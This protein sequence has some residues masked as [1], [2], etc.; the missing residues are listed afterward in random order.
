MEDWLH[1]SGERELYSGLVVRSCLQGEPWEYVHG[2]PI[3]DL[4]K[5]DGYKE[6]F[7]VLDLKYGRSVQ[8][9]KVRWM[10]EFFCI[11]RKERENVNDFVNRFDLVMRECM[12]HGMEALGEEHKGALLLGRCGLNE[13]DKRIIKGA[14]GE[15]V[16]YGK[17]RGTVIRLMEE[18][19]RK[20]REERNW[21]EGR[22]SD[23]RGVKCFK[24]NEWGH[25]ARWCKGKGEEEKEEECKWCQNRGHTEEKCWVKG[26]TCYKC[27][28][29]G[30]VA[31]Q[32]KEG[33]EKGER[34]ESKRK[35]IWMEGEIEEGD[36]TRGEMIVGIIDTGCKYTVIGN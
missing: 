20:K 36:R 19:E 1:G 23:K 32:C 13:T 12:S 6:I 10:D 5:R 16:S 29:K 35:Q 30:H 3:D 18:E 28:K 25:I 15:D 9:E 27:Q 4:K 34:V 11:M 8:S 33:S 26:R 22:I 7:K 31:S 24:C 2:I 17:V 21:T 14:I